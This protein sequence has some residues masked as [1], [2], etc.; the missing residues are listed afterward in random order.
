MDGQLLIPLE[1]IDAVEVFTGQSLDELL[2]RIR[3]ETATIVPDVS[4]AGGRKEIASLAYKIARSKTTIDDA[5]KTLVAEW[6]AK[7]AAVDA[8]RK[9]A[10]DYLDTLK[11]EVRKPLDEWEAEQARL[12]REA[13]KKAEDERKAA[14]AARLAEIEARE[15]EIREREEAIAA[16]ER[17]EAQR[18][19]AEK[20]D[21]ERQ[22]REERIRQ[23]AEAK[24]QRD[25]REAIERAA[26]EAEEAKDRDAAPPNARPR[27]P[28]RL[29]NVRSE[30]NRK[31]F[32]RLKNVRGMKLSGA[33]GLALLKMRAS[34]PNKSALLRI[35][36][37]VGASTTR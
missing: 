13:A 20:A 2:A 10:R 33:N 21:R 32:G 25:A 14:E 18:V 4:T 28:R 22:E 15:R 30:K 5:G 9:K 29:L 27:K 7:S 12:E 19:A 35:A 3:Q 6:K 37:T 17:A 24:A 16:R 23:E 36:L 26:R 31:R 11:D 34:A 8:A 1:H